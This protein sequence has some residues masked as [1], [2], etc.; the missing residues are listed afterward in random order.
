[1]KQAGTQWFQPYESI[2]KKTLV[3]LVRFRAWST[4]PQQNMRQQEHISQSHRQASFREQGRVHPLV[5]HQTGYRSDRC[6][7]LH[8]ITDG[9]AFVVVKANSL[10]LVFHSSSR[11]L[12]WFKW[13]TK[14]WCGIR[15]CCVSNKE[16]IRYFLRWTATQAWLDGGIHRRIGLR[17]RIV[18]R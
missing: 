15:L 10:S 4:S 13:S 11:I 3:P 2:Q 17:G 18:R 6:W 14:R 9:N 5:S 1:M 16:V 8:I 7:Y 12:K